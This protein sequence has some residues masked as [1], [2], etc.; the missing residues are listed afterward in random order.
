[1]ARLGRCRGRS[2]DFGAIVAFDRA[3]RRSVLRRLPL[4]NP[5]R[6]AETIRRE[7]Q[8]LAALASTDVPHPRLI[9]ACEETDPLGG[10][11]HIFEYIE[12]FSLWGAIPAI[13]REGQRAVHAVGLQIVDAFAALARV[14]HTVVE[15]ESVGTGRGWVT[16]QPGRWHRQLAG[17]SVRD[18]FRGERLPVS[19]SSLSMAR[20]ANTPRPCGARVDPRR[21][22]P[23][24]C[25]H[26][27]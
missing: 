18:G 24:Q 15:L 14:D 8:I 9:V 17:Y 5:A 22:A 27:E 21:R 10:L 12:G 26:S 19:R 2:A 16:R 20:F 4:D 11:I 6:S 23:R 7:A 25:P 13:L 1:M 3:G